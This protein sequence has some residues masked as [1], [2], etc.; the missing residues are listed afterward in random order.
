MRESI[1]RAAP[2]SAAKPEPGLRSRRRLCPSRRS[3]RRPAARRAPAAHRAPGGSSPTARA[4]RGTARGGEPRV[5]NMACARQRARETPEEK[6][7]REREKERGARRASASSTS[8]SSSGGTRRSS[9]GASPAARDDDARRGEPA[10]GGVAACGWRASLPPPFAV[11]P[12]FM[13]A[14]AGSDALSTGFSSPE[15]SSGETA[16]CHEHSRRRHIGDKRMSR[17]HSSSIES[18]KLLQEKGEGCLKIP[19]RCCAITHAARR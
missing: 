5:R 4:A 12:P 6:R 9:G 19:T 3:S 8:A 10:A 7:E 11:I 13:T 1:R 15:S 2:P 17:P 14:L 18:K 16:P